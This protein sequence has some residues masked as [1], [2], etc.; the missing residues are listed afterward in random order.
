MWFKPKAVI[1]VGLAASLAF[2]GMGETVRADGSVDVSTVSI[3]S[4]V[5]EYIEKGGEEAIA[6]LTGIIEVAEEPALPVEE[7]VEEAVTD[8]TETDAVKYAQFDGKAIAAV[9]TELNIRTDQEQEAEII[10]VLYRCGLCDVIEKGDEWTLV[11]S[12]DCKGYVR[13]KYLR[14]GDDAAAWSIENGYS[15][16]A[17]I[18]TDG[19]NVR[20]QP[21]EESE[22]LTVV[23]NGESYPVLEKGDK[24]TKVKLDDAQEGYVSTEYVT[25]GFKTSAA[26]PMEEI[27]AARKAEEEKKA[28]E[29]AEKEKTEEKKTADAGKADAKDAAP[30][31][32]QEQKTEEA[33]EAATEAATEEATEAA[34]EAPAEEPQK[35]YAQPAGSAGQDIAD[36]AA[37]FVGNPYRYGG[38]SLTDGAD[39]SGFVMSVYAAFGYS[40]PRVACDQVNTGVE[41]DMSDLQPGDIIGYGGSY[42]G[43]V[44]IYIG[45]GQI[46]HAAS[47]TQGIITQNYDYHTPTKAVRIVNN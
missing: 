14:F 21:D 12:G 26:V 29:E 46:V 2:S 22:S 38:T 35:T 23:Y 20:E 6:S 1:A 34:T 19:L 33:T 13:T 17:T 27:L 15:E 40:L 18:E 45:G 5:D 47:S 4:K 32:K 16:V 37:Q 10:G 41:V 42:I 39:C 43:H 11:E 31:E 8:A 25:V 9:E 24:W 36:Y 30:T 3:I 7:P 28:A 44:G